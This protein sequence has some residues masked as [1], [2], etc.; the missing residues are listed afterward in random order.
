MRQ[1]EGLTTQ[2]R[3]RNRVDLVVFQE[4][5]PQMPAGQGGDD[6]PRIAPVRASHRE[7]ADGRVGTVTGTSNGK[8]ADRKR[9]R[10]VRMSFA[11][12]PTRSWV[13]QAT[14]PRRT[15]RR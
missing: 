7:G 8:C 12:G 3:E 11:N 2:D 10:I 6:R 14:L 13:L 4:H 5:M 15:H 9:R 1:A